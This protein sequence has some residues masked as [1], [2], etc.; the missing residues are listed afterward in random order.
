ML[1]QVGVAALVTSGRSGIKNTREINLRERQAK[2]RQVKIHEVKAREPKTLEKK[3]RE[4]K[5][6]EKSR[7]ELDKLILEHRDNG[8]KLARSFLRK[9]R[10]RISLEEVDS[11]VDLTLCEAA[12]R[13][14]PEKGASF[15]TFVFY[16]LRGYL[17]RAVAGSANQN[18]IFSQYARHVG[19]DPNEFT[20]GE[21]ILQCFVPDCA[22]FGM[23]EIDCPEDLLMQKEKVELCRDACSQLDELEREVISR[24]FAEDE[25]LIDIAKSLGYSRCH[26]SRVKKRALD[27]LEGFIG[28]SGE[29][30]G[31]DANNDRRKPTCSGSIASGKPSLLKRK[32]RRRFKKKIRV[33]H[34]LILA[35]TA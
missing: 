15:M 35:Q 34:A 24:S 7:E 23:R 1:C 14:S 27:R 33:Q 3:A 4:T 11:L 2:V 21:E 22:S 32:T 10:A 8:R 17:V 20:G 5:I 13:Y 30:L 28:K 31:L 16:H 19:V 6:P 18:N 9:W 26:I 29:E 12:K 25:A